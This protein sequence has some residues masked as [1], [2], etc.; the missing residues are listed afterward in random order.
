[1]FDSNVIL[2]AE[3][4]AEIKVVGNSDMSPRADQRLCKKSLPR[5]QSCMEELVLKGKRAA[6]RMIAQK[7]GGALVKEGRDANKQFNKITSNIAKKLIQA[8]RNN[9]TPGQVPLPFLELSEIFQEPTSIHKD[10]RS[11]LS[12]S[13]VSKFSGCYFLEYTVEEVKSLVERS[14]DNE[15]ALKFCDPQLFVT[16]SDDKVLERVKQSPL[17]YAVWI[18]LESEGYNPVVARS[19]CHNCERD[20]S[21]QSVKYT[22]VLYSIALGLPMPEYSSGKLLPT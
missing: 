12:D 4:N 19:I 11:L 3:V 8:V 6:Q 13:R 14:F 15:W 10:A 17:L 20:G 16:C 22:T 18:Y 7:S 21:T 5:P 1:M 9:F 2:L